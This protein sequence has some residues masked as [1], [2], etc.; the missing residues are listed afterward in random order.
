MRSLGRHWASLIGAVLVVAMLSPSAIAQSASDY[1]KRRASSA[2]DLTFQEPKALRFFSTLNNAVFKPEGNG[3]FPAIVHFHTCGG[4]DMYRGRYWTEAALEA[5]FVVLVLDSLGPRGLSTLCD[6][7]PFN[8]KS[9]V[10][11]YRGVKDAFDA[12]AYLEKL[13]IVDR[14]RI[15]LVGFSWGAMAGILAATDSASEAF[16]TPFRAV[17]S[18]YPGCAR[19]LFQPDI[20]RPLLVLMGELDNEVNL[21]SCVGWL[22]QARLSGT[23]IESRTYPGATHSWDTDRHIRKTT[24]RG[25][26]VQYVPNP[27]VTQESRRDLFAF[28]NKHMPPNSGLQID[29][30]PAARD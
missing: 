15:A 7:S 8:D 29:A 27:E 6:I 2:P 25:V 11:V 4:I 19:P 1:L 22:E 10:S 21:P 17:A 24:N 12:K 16:G 13:A 28:L 30:P 23:K 5:G 26:F 3:P 9:G 14:S 18:F 20:A